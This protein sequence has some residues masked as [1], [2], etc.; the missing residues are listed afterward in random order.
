[1]DP[2]SYLQAKDSSI[3]TEVL[4]KLVEALKLQGVRTSINEELLPKHSGSYYDIDAEKRQLCRDRLKRFKIPVKTLQS[5]QGITEAYKLEIFRAHK[6]KQENVQRRGEDPATVFIQDTLPQSEGNSYVSCGLKHY[7]L[8]PE[9]RLAEKRP[10]ESVFQPVLSEYSHCIISS[11]ISKN[12]LL[13]ETIFNL[14]EEGE[15]NG[16]TEEMLANLFKD[17]MKKFFPSLV[18][19]VLN[20]TDVY[21]VMET[22]LAGL[23]TESDIQKVQGVISNVTR[24][25]GTP[26]AETAR[27]IQSLQEELNT[28]LNPREDPEK[29][30]KKAERQV[31]RVISSYVSEKTRRKYNEYKILCDRRNEELSLADIISFLQQLERKPGYEITE[32][33]QLSQGLVPILIHQNSV[34][35]SGKHFDIKCYGNNITNKGQVK[36][37]AMSSKRMG[38]VFNRERRDSMTGSRDS[39]NEQRRN[40]ANRRIPYQQRTAHR[41]DEEDRAQRAVIESRRR[42]KEATYRREEENEAQRAI[43]EKRRK[44]KEDLKTKWPRDGTQYEDEDSD[45]SYDSEDSDDSEDSYGSSEDDEMDMDVDMDENQK[46]GKNEAKENENYFCP[47]C[48]LWIGCGYNRCKKYPDLKIVKKP[49]SECRCQHEDLACLKERK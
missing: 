12:I 41:G 47:I 27:I 32:K 24:R 39:L 44:Q 28:L 10:L 23:S 26:L 20:K 42:H 34:K 1:M 30:K 2:A 48:L 8:D 15:L 11:P 40:S 22:L 16:L 45:G 7:G 4:I 14:I 5:H 3:N 46:K 18:Q 35:A 31:K 9:T 19:A 25:V 49:C 36:V 43:M 37:K 6:L 13:K 29:I 33:K 17:L 21:E 38:K